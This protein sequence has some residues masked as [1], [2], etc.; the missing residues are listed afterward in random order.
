MDAIEKLRGKPFKWNLN[1]VIM[2]DGA[3]ILRI[4]QLY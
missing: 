3:W 2:E 1:R 4:L